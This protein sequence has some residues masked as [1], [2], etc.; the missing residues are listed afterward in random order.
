MLYSILKV[1][2]HIDAAVAALPQ[3]ADLID[4]I[5]LVLDDE[6]AE[7]LEQA[8]ALAR[9]RS[10]KAHNDLQELVRAKTA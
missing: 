3:F 2:P 1:L 8:Y 9:T 7:T 6:D 10:D 5:K 4:Q